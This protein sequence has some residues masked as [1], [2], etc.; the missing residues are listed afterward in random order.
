MF[1]DINLCKKS[2][3]EMINARE[4]TLLEVVSVFVNEK[5]KNYESF[6]SRVFILPLVKLD[7]S[8]IVYHYRNLKLVQPNKSKQFLISVP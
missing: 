8:A 5:K 3:K 4:I 7:P 2:T 6:R 1:L